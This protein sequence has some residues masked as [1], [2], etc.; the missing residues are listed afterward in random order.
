MPSKQVAEEPLGFLLD[1]ED[2]GADLLPPRDK[3]ETWE[4]RLLVFRMRLEVGDHSSASP[5][6]SPSA[7][8]PACQSEAT[9]C[10][11][12]GREMALPF[13]SSPIQTPQNSGSSE[14]GCCD[15]GRSF[16]F[17]RTGSSDAQ[18]SRMALCEG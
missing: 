1:G 10:Q 4:P 9:L 15:F 5:A 8:G 11:S 18:P 17:T 2:V 16:I 3:P 7:A 14:R 13:S 12:V 6:I